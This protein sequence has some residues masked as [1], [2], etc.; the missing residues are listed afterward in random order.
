[1]VMLAYLFAA[2]S[3]KTD[4]GERLNEEQLEAIKRWERSNSIYPFFRKRGGMIGLA[5]SS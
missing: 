1:M 3:L 2:F 4:A 5:D